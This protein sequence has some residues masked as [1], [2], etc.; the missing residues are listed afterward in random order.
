LEAR[1]GSVPPER[2]ATLDGVADEGRLQGLVRL[3]A[4]CPDLD[5]FVAGLAAG[6]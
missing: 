2:L 1:F 5:T 3:A 6:K 4:T